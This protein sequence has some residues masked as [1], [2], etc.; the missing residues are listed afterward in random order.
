[1]SRKF[2]LATPVLIFLLILARF[3]VTA[4]ANWI[5]DTGMPA[6]V[7]FAVVNM[8]IAAAGIIAAFLTAAKW[9]SKLSY[10]MAMFLIV[11]SMG[12]SHMTPKGTLMHNAGS[13]GMWVF[14]IVAA[15]IALAFTARKATIPRS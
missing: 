3:R 9:T 11:V 5:I 6:H 8:A 15:A 7:G 10:M 2:I 12:L 14:P 4:F 1:M 13:L